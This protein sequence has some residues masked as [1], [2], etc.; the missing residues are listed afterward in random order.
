[1]IRDTVNEA[2]R[3]LDN[4]APCLIATD[5]ILLQKTLHPSGKAL[6]RFAMHRSSCNIGWLSFERG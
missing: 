5:K 3:S 6:D 2:P 1:M 4:V